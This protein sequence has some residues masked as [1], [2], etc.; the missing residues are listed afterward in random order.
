[1]IMGEIMMLLNK[2]VNIINSIHDIKKYCNF[3]DDYI[4][5]LVKHLHSELEKYS[6]SEQI[7]INKAYNLLNRIFTRDLYEHID[8]VVMSQKIDIKITNIDICIHIAKIGY[9]SGEKENPLDNLYF[10]NRYN[11]DG[12]IFA[13][14][15]SKHQKTILTPTKYQEYIYVFYLKNKANYDAL[16]EIKNIIKFLKQDVSN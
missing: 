9:V 7:I 12:N 10:H 5:F 15:I 8:T 2:I 11:K 4:I 3:T 14:K 1:M 13:Q 6:D 16:E